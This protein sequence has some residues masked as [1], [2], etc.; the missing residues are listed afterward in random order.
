MRCDVSDPSS[1]TRATR[2]KGHAR[3]VRHV[4]NSTP[5]HVAKG[6]RTAGQGGEPGVEPDTWDTREKARETR[7]RSVEFDTR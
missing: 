7:E 1:S 4:S 2:G 5:P 6:A 3:L